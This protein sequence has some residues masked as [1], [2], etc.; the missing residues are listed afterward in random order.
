MSQ[1]NGGEIVKSMTD[2]RQQTPRGDTPAPEDGGGRGGG[3]Q[4][5]GQT[6]ISTVTGDAQVKE[7]PAAPTRDQLYAGSP[8]AG[9][10]NG[11]L[12]TERQPSASMSRV[13]VEGMENVDSKEEEEYARLQQERRDREPLWF[14]RIIT[15]HPKKAFGKS[16]QIF[17]ML[18]S[19]HVGLIQIEIIDATSQVIAALQFQLVCVKLYLRSS[20]F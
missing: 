6:G 5:D 4:D 19:N 16:N 18:L 12:S 10:E 3:E 11:D 20:L 8:L 13:G 17:V 1:E 15:E 9:T 14:C 7:A 2:L